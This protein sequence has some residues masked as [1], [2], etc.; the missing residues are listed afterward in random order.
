MSSTLSCFYHVVTTLLVKYNSNTRQKDNHETITSLSSS[1]V[2]NH[3][4]VE[5][6]ESDTEENKD[7][8]KPFSQDSSLVRFNITSNPMEQPVHKGS[9]TVKFCFSDDQ[10]R[11]HTFSPIDEMGNDIRSC[12][13][14]PCFASFDDPLMV[15]G[16][17]TMEGKREPKKARRRGS[18]PEDNQNKSTSNSFIKK[19]LRYYIITIS[20]I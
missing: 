7:A 13:S 19:E 1:T 17:T 18:S 11:Y 16:S 20:G 2:S 9:S 6:F 4:V 3:F 15:V 5:H 8:N 10:G 14:S 12:H